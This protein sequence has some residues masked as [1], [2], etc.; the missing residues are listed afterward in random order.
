MS[1]QL[2]SAKI[3]DM[4]AQSANLSLDARRKVLEMLDAV[5][6]EIVVRLAG[7]NTSSFN[8]AQ[9]TVLKGQI[10]VL[11]KRF[12]TD[13]TKLIDS[14]EAQSFNLG[15]QT[16]VQPISVLGTQSLGQISTSAL[17]IAQA[18]TADLISGLSADAS[19]KVNAAIQRAFLGGQQIT[20]IIAQIG[21]AIGGDKFNGI[22]DAL[23]RR[24]SMITLNE[25]LRVQSIAAQARLEDAF[26]RLPDLQKQWRHLNLARVPRPGHIA[27]DRQVVAVKDFFIV[28]GEALM[29][30]RDPSG[31]AANTIN[32][33]CMMA[34]YFAPSVLKPTP[35]QKGLLESLGISV[36]AA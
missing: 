36:S 33:H 10:D 9:L 23:G 26:S 24:A 30:P 27:A 18:Y 20:D 4:I 21:K 13:A 22:F 7:M 2:F 12:S 16:I 19:A 32:C 31:S 15:S 14:Y 29:Y 11:F 28:E 25:I 34:P 6:K 1:A 3:A 5:R 35:S 8:A 17:T